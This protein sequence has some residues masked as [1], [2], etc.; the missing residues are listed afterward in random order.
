MVV[1]F[2]LKETKSILFIENNEYNGSTAVKLA[3]LLN[4]L[5]L[6]WRCRVDLVLLG[7]FSNL[8]EQNVLIKFQ[9]S[10]NVDLSTFFFQDSLLFLVVVFVKFQFIFSQL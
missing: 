8:T 9:N 4:Q 2:E 5:D 6:T 7:F 10:R 3:M 1:K